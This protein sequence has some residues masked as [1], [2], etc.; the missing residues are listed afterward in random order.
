M[1]LNFAS[2]SKVVTRH[3]MSDIYSDGSVQIYFSFFDSMKPFYETVSSVLHV[4]CIPDTHSRAVTVL[5]HTING[6]LRFVSLPS[7]A[8]GIFTWHG[9]SRFAA[10]QQ[11][12]QKH[13]ISLRHR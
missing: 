7:R 5:K 8:L 13:S 4:G 3:A 10:P 12:L 1:H 2:A 9:V 6:A 11:T